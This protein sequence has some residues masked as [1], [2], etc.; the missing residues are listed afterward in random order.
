MWRGKLLTAKAA[1]TH[2]IAIVV[3]RFLEKKDSVGRNSDRCSQQRLIKR[4]SKSKPA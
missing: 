2:K 3:T 1:T 4:E